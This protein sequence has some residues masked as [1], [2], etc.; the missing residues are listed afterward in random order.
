MSYKFHE[1]V[2]MA[3]IAF[4]A[5]APSL[6]KLLE[7]AAL[8]TFEVMAPLGGIEPKESRDIK[9]EAD[10]AEKLFFEWIEELIYLKDADSMLFSK[11]EIHVEKAGKWKLKAKA[12]GEPIDQ[13]KHKT[14][15]DVKAITYHH[16]SVKL[17]A[18][19]WKAHVVLDI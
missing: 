12:W 8:A 11:F 14:V 6:E 1:D 7:D 3:D 2:S 15:V 4:S 5:E 10:S 9:I 16:F 18:G 13:E 17:E 19:K